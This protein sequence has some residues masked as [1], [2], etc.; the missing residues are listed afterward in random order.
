VSKTKI[1]IL[2]ILVSAF[3]A[4]FMAFLFASGKVNIELVSRIQINAAYAL[5]RDSLDDPRYTYIDF[6]ADN[7]PVVKNKIEIAVAGDIVL[8]ENDVFVYQISVPYMGLYYFTLDYNASSNGY[9]DI[10]ISF[11]VNGETQ[12]SDANNIVL[13]VFWE[14]ESKIY[15]IDKYGDES[16]PL[17]KQISGPHT[18]S[19]FDTRYTTD[20]P[21]LFLLQQGINIIEIKNETSQ[22]VWLGGLTAYSYRKP[23]PYGVPGA[24]T[25]PDF[26]NISA[27]SYVKKN[28]PH[29]SN[30]SYSNPHTTPY[31][32]LYKKISTIT[33]ARAGNEVYYQLNASQDGYYAITFHCQ[34]A[35][36]DFASFVSVK[37]DGDFPFAE[38]ASYPLAPNVNVWRNQTMKDTEG[39]PFLVYLSRGNHTISIKT[40][41]SP[42]SRQ[43]HDLRLLIDHLNQFAIEIRK[44]TG[45]DIDRNRTWRLTQ[46]IPEVKD[47]L[48]AYDIVFRDIIQELSKYSPKG[49]DS[50]VITPLVQAVSY[51]EKLRKKPDELP[52]YTESLSGQNAS[53]LQQAGAALDSL[54]TLGMEI[55]AI[56]IGRAS[57][58]PKEKARLTTVMADGIKKLLYSYTSDK[59]VVRN[60]R[61]ALNIWYSSSYMQVDLLQKLIDTRFTPQTGI[62]V[63]L[64]VMPDVNKLIMARAART[65][66]DMALGLGSWIPFDLAVRGALYDLTQFNDFWQNMG[67]FIPGSL[68]SYVLNEKVYAVPETITFNAIVFREDILN[69]LNIAPPNTW[70]D[71][72]EMMAELQRFDMSFFMPIASGIGYKW[73]YQTS[74]LIYQNNGFL[75][76]PDGLGTAINETNSVKALTFLGELFTTYAIAEQVPVF[77]NSFRL[78]QTPVGIIDPE[79]YILLT[80]GAPELLG[81]WSMAPYPGTV[82]EDGSIVRWFITNGAG[83]SI[84]FENTAQADNCWK[85]LKWYLS[86]ETQTDFAFSLYTNYRILH[87]SSNVKALRNLPVEEKDLRVILEAVTWLRDVPRSPGQYL[88]ERGLSDI[89]N[90]M[91]FNGTPAQVAID[92]QVIEIQRE[93]KK[94][95][96]EFGYLNTMG[97]KVKPYLVHEVDWIIE[98]IK[99]AG[100]E[101]G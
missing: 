89:W 99:N 43:I 23:A 76:R 62:K 35:I 87:I 95:M 83:G 24:E 93:F 86:E 12:Y 78:G 44:V 50:S 55:D 84:I 77:F 19:L 48:D 98:Q 1:F 6:L 8:K 27:N 61:D 75:Y 56:Y 20:L 29:V 9:S 2:I 4:G 94:K 53:V 10:I 100:L 51:L 3:T 17:H 21:L 36:E 18:V 88:L 64:S 22:T 91:V 63:N 81:Q 33:S 38:A 82:Q 11:R 52:L 31:D 67:N 40:E 46:Y 5:L 34:T 68:T 28:S 26:I 73:Y 41:L 74:P 37:V 101:G 7:N 60:Q 15:P 72:A 65:N 54:Y 96:T 16:I 49:A 80:N 58:L 90:T 66:P 45:K 70:I 39:K 85:F 59:Y 42:V 30:N 57:S 47:Y 14:D 32:P 79:T 13:P 92:K 69:Q 25:V 71:V 97:E